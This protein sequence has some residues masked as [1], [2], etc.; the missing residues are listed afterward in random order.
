[1]MFIR[2]N[3]EGLDVN[4]SVSIGFLLCALVAT[5]GCATQSLMPVQQ[6]VNPPILAQEPK[7]QVDPPIVPAPRVANTLLAVDPSGALS[8]EILVTPEPSQMP[9]AVSPDGRYVLMYAP[10]D[11]QQMTPYLLDR[12]SGQ[13]HQGEPLHIHHMLWSGR[14]FWIDWLVHMDLQGQIDTYPQLRQALGL[15]DGNQ[16]VAASFSADGSRV[17]ALVGPTHMDP[18]ELS[19]DLILA[20]ADGTSLVRVAKA[21]QPWYTQQG[22]S[23]A[24]SLSPDGTQV[25]ISAESPRAAL[26]K[27]ADPNRA[28]WQAPG[29]MKIGGPVPTAQH[30]SPPGVSSLWSPDGRYVWMPMVGIVARDGT[31]NAPESS[32][33]WGLAWRA[34][35]TE[36]LLLGQP[37]AAGV[38]KVGGGVTQVTLPANTRP[39]GYLPDGRVLGRGAP[40]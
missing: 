22:A 7:A 5:T 8:P 36:I 16:L 35:S 6:P 39:L 2:Q 20:K 11:E 29:T 17:A 27:T 32:D 12:I 14:G 10:V 33:G 26:V 40:Q 37:S 34:D 21:I 23:A 13:L 9:A 1:M 15:N 28:R 4:R 38:A 30:T 25:A 31:V 24:V 18:H 19:L 3:Q